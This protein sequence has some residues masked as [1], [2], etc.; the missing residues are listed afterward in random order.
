MNFLGYN[1]N[2]LM[3]SFAPPSYALPQFGTDPGLRVPMQ[4]SEPGLRFPAPSTTG[5]GGAQLGGS[6]GIDLLGTGTKLMDSSKPK[7]QAF[8]PLG[9]LMPQSRADFNSL[10]A[11]Y[12]KTMGLLA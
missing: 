8:E 11:N 5:L 1:S 7:E 6:G 9:L 3:G 2:P 10:Y 12:L 4:G